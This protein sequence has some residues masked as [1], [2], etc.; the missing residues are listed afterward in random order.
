VL[1]LARAGDRQHHLRAREE[2]DIERT[3]GYL[4]LR[5]IMVTPQRDWGPTVY[6]SAPSWM[7]GGHAIELV[8]DADE[9]PKSAHP[10]DDGY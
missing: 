8:L 1:H 2:L 10:T 3:A 9:G 7:F 5:S 6:L 4:A